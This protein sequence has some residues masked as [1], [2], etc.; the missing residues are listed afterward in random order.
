MLKV[1]WRDI[2]SCEQ[3]LVDSQG[4]LDLLA[5]AEHS[6]GELA[7]CHSLH[8]QLDARPRGILT[9]A[10]NSSVNPAAISTNSSVPKYST[11]G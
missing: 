10:R 7:T 4:Y 1:L 11:A 8:C 9:Y 5:S 3:S 6:V 2:R